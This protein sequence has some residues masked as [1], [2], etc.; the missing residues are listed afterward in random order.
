[1]QESMTEFARSIKCTSRML[2]ILTKVLSM[3]AQTCYNNNML[4]AVLLVNVT[5]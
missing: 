5:F 4:V 1:M 3:L 2:A